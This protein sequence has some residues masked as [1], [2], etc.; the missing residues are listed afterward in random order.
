[1]LSF[2]ESFLEEDNVNCFIEKS[3]QRASFLGELASP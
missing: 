3:L 2:S 1:M